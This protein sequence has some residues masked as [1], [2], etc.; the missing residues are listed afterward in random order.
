MFLKFIAMTFRLMALR[1]SGLQKCAI[2]LA[3]PM[4]VLSV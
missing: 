2:R 1:L 4:N 3:V